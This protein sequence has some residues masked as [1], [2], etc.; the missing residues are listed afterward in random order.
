MQPGSVSL[1]YYAR[2]Y[3]FEWLSE[4]HLRE[5]A[6]PSANRVERTDLY[7]IAAS[8]METLHA[9]CAYQLLCTSLANVVDPLPNL[10][11]TDDS[12]SAHSQIVYSAGNRARPP[13]C[14]QMQSHADRHI[15][16]FS[17]NT[18]AAACAAHTFVWS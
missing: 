4:R 8:F 12:G 13:P 3:I 1:H 17:R 6:Y 9:P 2:D 14:M 7:V 11:G 10:R 18:S 16:Q 5:H 15:A